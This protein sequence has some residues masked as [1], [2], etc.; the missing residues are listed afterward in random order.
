MNFHGG[1]IYTL[2]NSVLDFSSNINPLGVPDSFRQELMARLD[3][4][5][6]YPDTHYRALRASLADYLG[7]QQPDWII[8]GNGAVEVIFKA[9]AALGT[10]RMVTLSPTFSEYAHAGRQAG[11]E[12]VD[13]AG[14]GPDF[15]A[16]RLEQL[17][18]FLR[19]GTL[20]VVC[21][22]NNPTGTFLSQ[23]AMC[24]LAEDLRAAGC[25]LIIDEAFIEFTD[26]YPA[27]S[28]VPQLEN[29][30]NLLIVRAATKFFG[31]PGIR[32]G[33]GVTANRQLAEGIGDLLEP[34]NVNAA[35]VIAGCTV[36]RDEDYIRRSREW[37]AMERP[38]LFGELSKIS[39]LTVYPSQANYHLV[40]MN[41]PE[42]NAWRW[43]ELMV[44]KGILVRTPDGFHHLT[45]FHLRLAVKDRAAN[46]KLIGALKEVAAEN[47]C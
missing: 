5:T 36:Y 27:N 39:A 32:L 23:G 13:L 24:R 44:A 37:L 40:R 45:P 31:M 4:L 41:T 47:G 16:L 26:G 42:I 8:P 1:D 28:M 33:F 30:Q 11:A 7:L 19:P 10:K 20:V 2:Q 38:F 35:A 43:K 21:N 29:F 22:P 18:G 25:F 46:L 17:A 6:H 14:Y 34:W 9:I 12:V 3:E 15:S